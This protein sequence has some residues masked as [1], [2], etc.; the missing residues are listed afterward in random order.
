MTRATALKKKRKEIHAQ[1]LI[2]RKSSLNQ[3]TLGRFIFGR[4]TQ[5]R[6]KK[7]KHKKK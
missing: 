7:N 2:E 6:N 5:K 3:V 4:I 1:N